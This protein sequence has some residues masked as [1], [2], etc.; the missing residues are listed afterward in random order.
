[1]AD[2]KRVRVTWSGSAVV[3]P[4]VSTFYFAS[5]ATGFPAKLQTFFQAIKSS[6]PVTAT[7]T[8][9]NT[10]DVINEATGALSGVWTDS[11]GSTTVGTGAFPYPAGVGIRVRWVTGGVRHGRR[12][13]GSTFLVPVVNPAY[14]TDGTIIPAT[15]TTIGTAVNA[16]VTSAAGDQ[17]IWS[18]PTP[19]GGSDGTS[20]SVLAGFVPDMVT[21][22]RSRRV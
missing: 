3:G 16:F 8:V 18:K 11:G 17:H 10:G 2:L 21:S 5:A 1:M 19:P 12:V 4:G 6:F 7:I 9:P 13:V 14:D 20:S 15:L 22:L